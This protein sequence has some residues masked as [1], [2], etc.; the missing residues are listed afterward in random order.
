MATSLQLTVGERYSIITLVCT[1]HTSRKASA[2]AHTD[3]PL[4]IIPTLTIRIT[5]PVFIPYILLVR[6]FPTM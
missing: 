5:N 2:H 3:Y 4:R 1:A 6:D